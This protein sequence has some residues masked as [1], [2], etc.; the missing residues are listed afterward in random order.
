MKTS[1]ASSSTEHPNAPHKRVPVSSEKK[2]KKSLEAVRVGMT[3]ADSLAT[4]RC[5]DTDLM[6]VI[7]LEGERKGGSQ[8]LRVAMFLSKDVRVAISHS[9]SDNRA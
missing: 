1:T 5:G 9:D 7:K 6:Q 3:Q 4:R 2:T 8:W